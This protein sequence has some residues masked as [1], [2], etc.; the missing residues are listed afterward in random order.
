[1]FGGEQDNYYYYKEFND[2]KYLKSINE[3]SLE[4][5]FSKAVCGTV[6]KYTNL[7]N[8]VTFNINHNFAILPNKYLELIKK[9]LIGEYY[10]KKG[11]CSVEANSKIEYFKYIMCSK[12]GISLSKYNDIKDLR[13]FPNSTEEHYFL[14]LKYNDILI[15]DSFY[16]H[17]KEK[18][19]YILMI[20]FDS[21]E[22]AYDGWILGNHY[23]KIFNFSFSFID[24]TLL[25]YKNELKYDIEYDDHIK[26]YLL[27]I[28][29]IILSLRF[30]IVIYFI[31]KKSSE[32]VLINIKRIIEII[33][34]I[35]Y[36]CFIPPTLK[37][38]SR[39]PFFKF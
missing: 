22:N 8:K 6:K 9:E 14:N 7:P 37:Y 36:F 3:N 29:Y 15:E 33:L 5:K 31:Y 35:S 27:N 30:L 21:R 2:R 4:Y 24:G 32:K 12:N 16:L 1:M 23:F 39:A 25:Y 38:T 18:G 19:K 34:I 11:Y 13:F 26:E 28:L 17:D 20:Y 10:F